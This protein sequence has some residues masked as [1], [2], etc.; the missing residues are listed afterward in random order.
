MNNGDFDYYNKQTDGQEGR[1]QRPHSA[2]E[3]ISGVVDS[4]SRP[5]TMLYSVLSLACGIGALF[6][7]AF[8]GWF[9]LFIGALAIVFSIVSR[10]HLGYF[11][12]K[13]VIGLVLGIAGAVFGIA[14]ILLRELLESGALDAFLAEFFKAADPD[15]N[16]T[17]PANNGT[18]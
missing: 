6:L 1:Y 10:R 9:G 18:V 16:P 4:L 5:R 14:V 17:P 7:A 11:D 2:S 12:T 3:D 15:T 8:G 13:A